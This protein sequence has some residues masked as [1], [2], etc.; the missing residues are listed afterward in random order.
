[1]SNLLFK[2]QFFSKVFKTY[3][4]A[5]IKNQTKLWTKSRKEYFQFPDFC[6]SFS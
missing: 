2:N 5:D 6:S 3:A 4:K 1:M